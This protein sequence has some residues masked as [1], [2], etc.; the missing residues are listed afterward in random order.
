L[1]ETLPQ[2]KGT[3]TL[4]VEIDECGIKRDRICELIAF[5]KM[6]NQLVSLI[7]HR[8]EL[9]LVTVELVGIAV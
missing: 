8:R 2:V 9:H 4:L 3:L 6:M 5:E 1:F 7:D